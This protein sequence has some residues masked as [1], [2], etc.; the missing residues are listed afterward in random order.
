MATWVRPNYSRQAV[1]DAG[2]VLRRR[3]KTSDEYAEAIRAIYNWRAAHSFPLNTF[4]TTLRKK[5]RQVD[6]DNLVAQRLK[7]FSSIYAKLMRFRDI[8]MSEMQDIAGCRAVVPTVRDVEELVSLYKNGNLKHEPVDADD[9]INGPKRT[10]YRGYHLIYRY[11]SD[12]TKPWN[13]LK[14]EVQLRSTLQHAWAT[15]VETVDTFT[16]QA[17]KAGGGSREWRMFFRLMSADLAFREGTPR[18]PD[19]PDD[20]AQLR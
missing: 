20:R 14:V 4:Q 18:V 9:Y 12:K 6:D 5:A 7:R 13:G 10:G 2:D 17:L 19:T 15:T 16:T 11:K 8:P 3:V 1:D